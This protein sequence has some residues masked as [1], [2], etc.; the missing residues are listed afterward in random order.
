M[1]TSWI[2]GNVYMA[3]SCEGKKTTLTEYTGP[4]GWLEVGRGANNRTLEKTLLAKSKEAIA[5]YFSW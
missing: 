2:L 3:K 1:S 5:G 4:P